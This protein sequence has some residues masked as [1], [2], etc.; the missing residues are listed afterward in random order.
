MQ[1]AQ[2]PNLPVL[3]DGKTP[4]FENWLMAMKDK[5][6]GNM[7]HYN[8]LTFWMGYVHSRTSDQALSHLALRS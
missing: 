4:T 1:M 6:M 8:T 3:L 5:M 7:D 2:L